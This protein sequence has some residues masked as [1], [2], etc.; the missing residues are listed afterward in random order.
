MKELRGGGG[1]GGGG[2][3]GGDEIP[4][5]DDGAYPTEDDDLV[6]GVAEVGSPPHMQADL[7]YLHRSLHK[8]RAQNKAVC[9]AKNQPRWSFGGTKLYTYVQTF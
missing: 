7:Q 8:V 2:G 3:M 6:G 4:S 9:A 5:N 1:G